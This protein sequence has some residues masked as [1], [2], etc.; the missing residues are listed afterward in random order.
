MQT[1][2]AFARCVFLRFSIEAG[3]L[4]FSICLDQYTYPALVEFSLKSA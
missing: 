4:K 3:M 1:N 2:G